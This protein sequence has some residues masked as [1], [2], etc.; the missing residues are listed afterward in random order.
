VNKQNPATIDQLKGILN[1]LSDKKVEKINK[2]VDD[3]D[4]V[5]KA[6]RNFQQEVLQDSTNL[7]VHA[8]ALTNKI[9]V[10]DAQIKTLDI[11]VQ[12]ERDKIIENNNKV[13]PDCPGGLKYSSNQHLG[14]ER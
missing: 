3:A 4:K 14:R 10:K 12:K 11:K 1:E 7:E 9:L 6:L 2:L 8:L 5:T 13:Y